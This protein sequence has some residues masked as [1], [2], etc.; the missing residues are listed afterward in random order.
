MAELAS[1]MVGL[2]AERVQVGTSLHDL[3]DT[4]RGAPKEFQKG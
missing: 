4:I 1:T 2:D 3:M